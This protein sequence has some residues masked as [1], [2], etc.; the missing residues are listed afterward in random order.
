MKNS[1]DKDENHVL[2]KLLATENITFNQ[3]KQ[4]KKNDDFMGPD[5]KSL[6]EYKN[7][8]QNK[9]MIKHF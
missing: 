4:F 2:T 9:S 5:H 8:C 6:L 7:N 1:C 3:L